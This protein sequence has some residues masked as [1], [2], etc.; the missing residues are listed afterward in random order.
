MDLESIKKHARQFI[1]LKDE[2]GVLTTR[3]NELKA[4][5]MAQLDE[6]EPDTSGHR[7]LE[8]NDDT[9]GDI[10]LTKQRRVSNPL[11][12]QVADEILTKKGIRGACIKTVEV[13]D[14]AAIMAAFYEG[15]L[16]EQEIDTMFP[17]KESYAFLVNR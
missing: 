1:F 10:K 9:L 12:M 16:T 5:M 14:E 8:F 6:V 13:L 2:I 3:Q 17:P 4:R 7:I 15:H 11:D